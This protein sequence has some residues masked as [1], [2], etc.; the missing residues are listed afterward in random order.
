MSRN[1][2]W[3]LSFLLSAAVTAQAVTPYDLV[4]QGG[5]VMDPE[6]GLDAVRNVGI[7]AG[8]ILR[9]SA[10]PLTG[11]RTL[12]A[13]GLVVAP[14][15]IDL[16]Q[17]AQDDASSR[18]KALDGVTSGIEME[19]GVPDIGAFL[20]RKSGHSLIHYGTSASHPAARARAFGTP[21]DEPFLVPPAGPCTNDPATPAQLQTLTARLEAEIARGALG[22]GMGVQYTPGATRAEV[23]DI[24][25]LAAAHQL[26]VFTHVRSFGKIEPGSSIEAVSEVIGAAAITGASLQIV[27]INSSC[28]ADAPACM[29]LIAGARARGLDVTTE[30]YPYLAGMTTINSALFNPGWREKLGVNYD[31]LQLPD[32]GEILTK[33]RFEA[34]HAA[35][36][37][38]PVLLFANTQATVDAVIASALVSIASDGED[39]H[40]RNAGTFSHVL[41]RY[42]RDLRTVTLMDAL[43]KMSLMPAQRLEKATTAARRK[44]RLQEGADADIVVFDPL[45]VTD[46]ATY[47]APR[48]PSTGMHYVLVAGTVLI[49]H[50]RVMDGAYP[51]RAI[52]ADQRSP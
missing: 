43:R 46:H 19:I 11:T 14:G 50:G 51:G 4:I 8:R 12:D 20:Q 47:A 3:L 48:A 34:L 13:Q 6:T 40:P 44:G 30:A 18:L 33:E 10:Q 42:V 41:A 38:Q 31:A 16:H 29:D 36:A 37:A 28:V 22:I 23:I 45:T 15:F 7:T 9:I 27:H 5:R 35:P 52:L 2:L 24:F 21:I 25:R 17:H 32:T 49:D 39:G 1:P 26:P